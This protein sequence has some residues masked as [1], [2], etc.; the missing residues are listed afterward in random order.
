MFEIRRVSHRQHALFPLSVSLARVRNPDQQVDFM[1][2]RSVLIL[3]I[4]LRV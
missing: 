2:F 3:T 4:D 1:K